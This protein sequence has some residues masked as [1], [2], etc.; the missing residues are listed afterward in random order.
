M[1]VSTKTRSPLMKSLAIG[2]P[3]SFR[4]QSQPALQQAQLAIAGLIEA[5]ASDNLFLERRISSGISR[6]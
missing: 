1:L 5:G 6:S 2:G 3:L 4:S